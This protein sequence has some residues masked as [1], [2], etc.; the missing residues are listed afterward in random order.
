MISQDIT[1]IGTGAQDWKGYERDGK[2]L[3][4]HPAGGPPQHR[5]RFI[6][7]SVSFWRHV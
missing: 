4:I 7:R 5:W 2:T 6:A 1:E 3:P